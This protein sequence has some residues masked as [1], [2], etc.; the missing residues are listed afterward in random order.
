MAVEKLF[1]SAI[2]GQTFQEHHFFSF[3]ASLYWYPKHRSLNL[4]PEP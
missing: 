2:T 4:K 1:V 3:V